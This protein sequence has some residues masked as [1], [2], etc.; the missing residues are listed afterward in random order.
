MT[1]ALL[2]PR[3]QNQELKAKKKKNSSLRQSYILTSNKKRSQ[4][5]PGEDAICLLSH[6]VMVQYNTR[7]HTQS[8]PSFTLCNCLDRNCKKR[9]T[10]YKFLLK[11]TKV[12]TI[13]SPAYS[14]F[15]VCIL[16][17]LKKKKVMNH[18][19]D[20]SAE[21][22]GKTQLL[23]F[24]MSFWHRSPQLIVVLQIYLSPPFATWCLHPSPLWERA[25]HGCFQPL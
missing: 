16:I 11:G 24:C 19:S 4:G 17:F 9:Q 10:E 5:T 23:V 14:T 1:W 12:G 3:H 7:K 8:L 22:P 18:C 2:T 20:F 21:L 13:F 6:L 25:S 15:I